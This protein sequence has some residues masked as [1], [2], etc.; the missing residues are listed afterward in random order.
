MPEKYSGASSVS[1]AALCPLERMCGKDILKQIESYI[2]L[3]RFYYFKVEW[4]FYFTCV[5]LK[6]VYRQNL[7]PRFICLHVPLE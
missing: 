2:K 6:F 3:P 4:E 7:F 5:F 1:K